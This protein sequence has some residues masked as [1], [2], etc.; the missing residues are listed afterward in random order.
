MLSQSVMQEVGD[1]NPV[2]LAAQVYGF[3]T[4]LDFLRDTASKR[5][6]GDDVAESH[7]SAYAET[8]DDPKRKIPFFAI[9][10]IETAFPSKLAEQADR[11]RAAREPK[12]R[13][14]VTKKEPPRRCQSSRR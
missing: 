5:N 2:I 3:D 10:D 9:G 1:R 13:A 4:D 8:R 7:I 6:I 11:A 14:K 12:P